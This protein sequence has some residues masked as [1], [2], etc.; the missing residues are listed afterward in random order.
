M[1]AGRRGGA[2]G[3]GRLSVERETGRPPSALCGP[4]GA[5]SEQVLS[6]CWARRSHS[7]FAR[8]QAA[9]PGAFSAQSL[10]SLCALAGCS[11][12]N[13]PCP[14]LSHSARRAWSFTSCLFPFR[15]PGQ[16]R[17]PPQRPVLGQLPAAH[18][19]PAAP[20]P[21]RAGGPQHPAAAPHFHPGPA[22]APAPLRPEDPHPVGLGPGAGPPALLC[23]TGRGRLPGGE[24]AQVLPR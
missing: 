20:G 6:G 2:A 19:Q 7:G 12:G 13:G 5:G 22:P 1:A 24:V 18:Q 4:L 23:H 9:R 16:P 8:P 15:Q 11:V 10:T 3:E 21:Q 14:P 17:L